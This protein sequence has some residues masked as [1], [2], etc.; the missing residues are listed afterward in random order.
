LLVLLSTVGQGKPGEGDHRET[1]SSQA[2]RERDPT[3]VTIDEEG[4]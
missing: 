3:E 1:S 2:G 4:W